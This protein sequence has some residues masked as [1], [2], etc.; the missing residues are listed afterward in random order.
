MNCFF[1]PASNR[2]ETNYPNLFSI[3]REIKKLHLSN[4]YRE[5]E[6]EVEAIENQLQTLNPEQFQEGIEQLLN[7]QAKDNGLNDSNTHKEVKQAI[8]D[9]KANPTRENLIKA[10]E[11]ICQNVADNKLIEICQE[12]ETKLSKEKL[13]KKQ[14]KKLVDKI[15]EAISKN[16]YQVLAYEK[17]KSKVDNLREQL[18]QK[19][20]MEEPEEEQT[21]LPKWFWPVAIT[22]GVLV[23]VLSIA[24]W[25]KERNKEKN[26]KVLTRSY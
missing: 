25:I 22:S 5:K 7:C 20:D 2:I 14:I 17:V 4:F 8:D 24:L 13:S 1:E 21:S 10:E 9:W 19:L 6:S 23:A 26:R 18:N 3:L 12:V 11:A 15:Q 16:D